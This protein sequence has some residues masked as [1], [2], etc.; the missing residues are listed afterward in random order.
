MPPFLRAWDPTIWLSDKRCGPFPLLVELVVQGGGLERGVEDLELELPP[1]L[2]DAIR[3]VPMEVEMLIATRLEEEGR[4]E[5]EFEEELE[6]E[7]FT[8][9]DDR[10]CCCC[11][12]ATCVSK[13]RRWTVLEDEDTEEEVA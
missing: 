4:G 1:L 8:T 6:D 7:M 2:L 13:S 5:L 3:D 9:G 10:L 11:G 12:R